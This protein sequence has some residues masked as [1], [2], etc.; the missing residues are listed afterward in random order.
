MRDFKGLKLDHIETWRADNENLFAIVQRAR[1]FIDKLN[2]YLTFSWRIEREREDTKTGITEWQR[3]KIQRQRERRYIDRESEDTKTE[4]EKIQ[5]Q[6]IE[7]DREDGERERE[8]MKW[9]R[10]K[11]RE[12]RMREKKLL[13]RVVRS[14]VK[15][16]ER[17][18]IRN[19]LKL[20]ENEEGSVIYCWTYIAT[21]WLG[22]GCKEWS[23]H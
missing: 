15:W 12:K 17:F 1:K 11:E 3:E 10:L 5:R 2:F 13:E 14:K 21:C 16:L 22:F 6:K 19:S 18:L 4:R 7:K 8:T 20:E 23:V 9:G